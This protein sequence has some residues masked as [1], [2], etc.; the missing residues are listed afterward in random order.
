MSLFDCF[1]L[2]TLPTDIVSILNRYGKYEF[3]R[4]TLKWEVQL[5]HDRSY[6]L[7]VHYCR[8][9]T[10]G[11]TVVLCTNSSHFN[12]YI[13]SE[14]HSTFLLPEG[15]YAGD[16]CVLENTIYI[17]HNKRSSN[18]E[19]KISLLNLNGEVV[20]EIT[21]SKCMCFFNIDKNGN[22][23]G[24]T[25]SYNQM[26]VNCLIDIFSN[27]G[28]LIR[29]LQVNHRVGMIVPQG[30][31]MYVLCHLEP[32][33]NFLKKYDIFGKEVDAYYGLQRLLISPCGEL[34]FFIFDMTFVTK[35][36]RIINLTPPL[37][38]AYVASASIAANGNLVVVFGDLNDSTKR[39]ICCYK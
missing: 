11:I 21:I 30:V 32:S 15:F 14:H 34:I 24:W 3:F 19:T 6:D 37:D 20:R 23:I 12:V 8:V 7:F 29:S 38:H 27:D 16:I 5:E 39:K 9:Y 17:L 1:A 35:T 2:Q 4:G 10:S 26:E 28:M 18:D 22:I 25:N 33:V 31:D 13:G 36:G